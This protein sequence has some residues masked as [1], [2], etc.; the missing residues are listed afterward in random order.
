[1]FKPTFHRDFIAQ[2]GDRQITAT[3]HSQITGI[4]S[5][6]TSYENVLTRLL[7]DGMWLEAY[8]RCLSHPFEC[9][10]VTLQSRKDVIYSYTPLGIGCRKFT[11][12]MVMIPQA[13]T[14]ATYPQYISQLDI[15][16]TL[17]KACP[18]QLRCNQI[19]V[20]QTPLLDILRNQ[21]ANVQVVKF[22]VDADKDLARRN[23]SDTNVFE[24]MALCRR[25]CNGLLPLH[26]L[27]TQLHLNETILPEETRALDLIEYIYPEFANFQE[28]RCDYTYTS[29]LIHLLSQNA[30]N[31]KKKQKHMH[32][33]TK[34]AEILLSLKPDLIHTKSIMTACTPLHMALRNGYG[35]YSELVALLLKYDPDGLNLAHKNKFGDLPIHVIATIGVCKDTWSILL[36]HISKVSLERNKNNYDPIE[37]PSP[38][39]FSANK[40][41]LTPIHLQW[42]RQ[43]SG[44]LHYP[45]SYTRNLHISHRQGKYYDT[46]EA[47]VNRIISIVDEKSNETVDIDELASESLGHTWEVIK[48]LLKTVH[49][50]SPQDKS[51]MQTYDYILHATCSLIGPSLPHPVFHLI[52]ELFKHQVNEVDSFGRTPLHY[53]CASFLMIKNA[54]FVVPLKSIGWYEVDNVSQTVDE[55]KHSTIERLLAS[56]Q[57]AAALSDKNGFH[58]LHF[59]IESEKLSRDVDLK[60]NSYKKWCV[61]RSLGHCVVDWPSSV[62]RVAVACPDVLGMPVS[63]VGLYPFMMA[64]TKPMGN[65]VDIVY[66]LLKMFP[67][68][69]IIKPHLNHTY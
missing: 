14:T 28:G 25:D 18:C 63:D 59:A 21:N 32:R 16:I 26:N 50:H 56:N 37:G 13:Y 17:F 19:K 69:A 65:S 22:F 42:M 6:R 57:N 10:P 68:T 36:N 2:F 41:G 47:A 7:D 27:V 15:L 39:I 30:G 29:P 48:L 11:N 64:A 67:I 61:H 24:S 4:Q 5:F 31:Q 53:A 66:C 55:S 35:D 45:M 23:Y 54:S 43:I 8:L 51:E 46:L 44:E 33:I 38:L 62:K 52:F 40:Y 1:M 9:M 58:P 3:S 60:V 34:C 49:Y 12:K 20:G